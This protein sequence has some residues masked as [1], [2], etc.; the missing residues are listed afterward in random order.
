MHIVPVDE[1]ERAQ[2]FAVITIS[3]GHDFDILQQP[4]NS[5][6]YRP[7]SSDGSSCDEMDEEDYEGDNVSMSRF[8]REESIEPDIFEM[9][10]LE[11]RFDQRLLD[12][13]KGFTFGYRNKSGKCN[14]DICLGSGNLRGTAFSIAPNAAH[15]IIL[16]AWSG[17]ATT[18]RINKPS[19][20][21]TLDGGRHFL[22]HGPGAQE[23]QSAFIH[24][25]AN[26]F[27]R[28]VLQIQF[29][30]QG[31][32]TREYRENLS[33]FQQY[34]QQQKVEQQKQLAVAARDTRSRQK[35]PVSSKIAEEMYEPYL[36]KTGNRLGSGAFG[37]VDKVVDMR[38]G[39]L[40]A[41]KQSKGAGDIYTKGELSPDLKMHNYG[42][43]C[44][45]LQNENSIL[46]TLDHVSLFVTS[47]SFYC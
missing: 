24:I 43:S 11:L 33:I 42:E 44:L 1:S 18:V 34:Y 28:I 4:H 41:L 36:Q 8:T 32:P 16:T 5:I 38:T 29:P 26:P 37:D 14:A 46:A 23:W 30:N 40:Y 35:D 17:A 19:T 9:R 21:V 47:L 31:H 15:E 10:R 12:P 2:L 22:S 7:S 27:R 25:Q 3:S 45:D 20:S 6:F 13:S 39:K